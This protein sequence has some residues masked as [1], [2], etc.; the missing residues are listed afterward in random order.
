M[1]INYVFMLYI[2]IYT[3]TACYHIDVQNNCILKYYTYI[4]STLYI[5]MMILVI[6]DNH[7]II[8]MHKYPIVMKRHIPQNL[9]ISSNNECNDTHMSFSEIYVP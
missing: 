7:G 6:N 9:H 4:L 2:Y 1:A 8:F 3:F 5:I